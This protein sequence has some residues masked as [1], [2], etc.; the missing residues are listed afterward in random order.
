MAAQPAQ[1]VQLVRKVMLVIKAQ[2]VHKVMLV[3]AVL[4]A[5]LVLH[6]LAQLVTKAV[7]VHKARSHKA[8]QALLVIKALKV[9]LQPAQQAQRAR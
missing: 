5:Q 4:Q 1:P 3:R 2:P 8:L 6:Q 9:H 7:P